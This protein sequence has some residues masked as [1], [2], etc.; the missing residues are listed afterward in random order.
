MQSVF[1]PLPWAGWLTAFELCS[2]HKDEPQE[3]KPPRRARTAGPA[4]VC[5]SEMLASLT[6]ATLGTAATHLEQR[7][8]AA[9]AEPPPAP[10][11]A[12]TAD[13][14]TDRAEPHCAEDNGVEDEASPDRPQRCPHRRRLFLEA[15][16]TWDPTKG[17]R[18]P[19]PNKRCWDSTICARAGKVDLRVR[20]KRQARPASSTGC[21]TAQSEL[22][23]V[24]RRPGVPRFDGEVEV[25]VE[26][27]AH[28]WWEL[29]GGFQGGSESQGRALR[30]G[31]RDC[32]RAQQAEQ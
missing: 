8:R 31:D 30:A 12:H 22:S 25:K 26:A 24:W 28:D 15:I 6:R 3:A 13:H 5:M 4:A 10:G 32:P 9:R 29:R 17:R 2:G 27:K 14:Q 11:P 7:I 16:G 1:L 21:W 20:A 19:R 23:G 18:R